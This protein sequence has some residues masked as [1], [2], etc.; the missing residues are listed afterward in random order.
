[1]K[2]LE[3]QLGQ[4]EYVELIRSVLEDEPTYIFKHALVQDTAYGS[5]LKQDRKMLHRQVG[6]AIERAYSDHQEQVAALL[7]KHYFEAGD[8][9][10]TLHFSTLAGDAA[11]RVYANPEA[12]AHYELA[13]DTIRRAE[14]SSASLPSDEII[15]LFKSYGRALELVSRYHQAAES[16]Q[17]LESLARMHQD[18]AMELAALLERAKIY[19]TINSEHDPAQGKLLSER[20]LEIAREIGDR[21]SECQVLWN[22]QITANY[23]LSD[24]HDAVSYGEQAAAI[25]RSLNLRDQLAYVLADLACSCWGTG[26]LDKSQNVLIESRKMWLESGNLPMLS[27]NDCSASI[28]AFLRGEYAEAIKFADEGDEVSRSSGNLWG[29]THSHY[30]DGYVRFLRGETDD[31]FRVLKETV[32]VGEQVGHPVGTI[33]VRGQLAWALGATGELEQGLAVAAAA[34]ELADKHLPSLRAWAL[35]VRARLE[36]LQGEWPRALE[37][38]NLAKK[39][40]Q[41]EAW[42]PLN[43]IW[44][45]L[46]SIEVALASGEN[47]R[48]IR[49]SDELLNELRE[50]HIEAFTAQV[51][52]LRGIAHAQ[53]KQFEQMDGD[54]AQSLDQARQLGE[55]YTEWRALMSWSEWARDSK[56]AEEFRR[57]AQ[58]AYPSQASRTA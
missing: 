12:L 27:Q 2:D 57:S 47:S 13:L 10:K 26:E 38:V 48:A 44:V 15:H 54:F 56:Q 32:K 34:Q 17:E 50:M 33:I 45:A 6:E 42:I 41:R 14:Q 19:G 52:L 46:A 28:T 20:A 24:L 25:A 9:G 7:A 3:A 36:V 5:L 39:L 30:V 49:E 4:L 51:L 31:A 58:A 22:L 21:A 11:M 53:D 35:A 8:D 40:L 55:R 23:S 29:Q 16:Y 1:M 37:T 43:P 18:R